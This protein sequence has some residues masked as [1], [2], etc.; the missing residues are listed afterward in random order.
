MGLGKAYSYFNLSVKI[1]Y[2]NLC[3]RRVH[4][5]SSGAL[6]GALQL[7]PDSSNISVILVSLLSFFIQ[8]ETFLVLGMMTVLLKSGHLWY[9]IMRFWLLF[10]SMG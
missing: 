8:I 3:F 4:N 10:Q 1:F 6:T 5:C 2:F 9:Y 7:L